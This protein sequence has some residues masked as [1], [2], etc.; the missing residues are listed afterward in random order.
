VGAAGAVYGL[1]SRFVGRDLAVVAGSLFLV[2]PILLDQR[3]VGNIDVM[4]AYFYLSAAIM[5]LDASAKRPDKEA[6]SDRM[7]PG[8]E[9]RP[10]NRLRGAEEETD[11]RRPVRRALSVAI[12][13]GFMLGMKYTAIL[14]CAA[15]LLIPALTASWAWKRTAFMIAVALLVFSPWLIKNQVYV[16]NPVYPL[17]EDTFD[18][19]NWDRTQSSQLISWQRSMGMGRNALDYLLLPINISTMGKPGSNYTRFDGVLSPVFLILVPLAF[20][21]R[22]RR[23]TAIILMVGAG[24]VFW[25][26]TSQQLRFLIPT[27]GLAA[28]LAAVGLHNLRTWVGPKGFYAVLILLLLVQVSSL[29]VPDQ[30]GR[31]LLSTIYD[32][33]PAAAGLEQ[34]REFLGRNI[35]SYSLFDQMNENIPPGQAVFLIWENRGYYLD[36]PYFAD[37]FF[38]ASTLMRMVA[39]CASPA[40][41]KQRITAMG[42][43]YVVVNDLLGE[44]FSQAYPPRDRE[45]LDDFIAGHLT[46]VHS[47]N[48][49]TLYTIDD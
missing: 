35:Q 38:E 12:L 1:A 2:Q 24:L 17:L 20:F 19:L 28:V 4:L 34:R 21:M 8:V 31:P 27:L 5:L 37:S 16:G 49:L 6:G 26:L 43:R 23:T 11:G 3:I 46:P 42:Y 48:R 9:T 15:L 47:V 33:L 18:G 22:R 44:V 29:I 30:Y 36:R 39:G 13:A 32:R 14:P 7:S 25:A 41:L 40:G 10:R 45:L